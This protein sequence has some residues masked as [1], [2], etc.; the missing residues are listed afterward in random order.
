MVELYIKSLYP[1]VGP[2]AG[3]PVH[4]DIEFSKQVIDDVFSADGTYAIV[5]KG[6]EE[7]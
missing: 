3:W 2:I 4:T 7:P 1:R 5:P 6:Q